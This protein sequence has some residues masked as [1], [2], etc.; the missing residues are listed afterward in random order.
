MHMTFHTRGHGVDYRV[1]E[2]SFPSFLLPYHSELVVGIISG[3][4]NHHVI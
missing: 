1:F 4:K 3:S 2:S